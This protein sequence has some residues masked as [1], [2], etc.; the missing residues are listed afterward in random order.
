MFLAEKIG[1]YPIVAAEKATERLISGNYQTSVPVE[2]PGKEFIGKIEL[3]YR[4]GRFEEVLLPYYRF[5]VQLP[6]T[7]NQSAAEKGLKTYGG[8][9]D[10]AIED[11]YITNMPL[12]DGSFN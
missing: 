9:Y 5:Y 8:Y 7:V 6:D 1:D 12:Y 3:V 11:E 10:P 4:A 2:F